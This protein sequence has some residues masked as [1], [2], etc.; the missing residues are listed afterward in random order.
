MRQEALCE[1]WKQGC[2]DG[3]R[4]LVFDRYSATSASRIPWPRSLTGSTGLHGLCG[5]F[6]SS[7]ATRLANSAAP[8][9]P[10]ETELMA[11]RCWANVGQRSC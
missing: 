3:W 4:K 11:N 8:T 7:A 1:I 5:M 2:S 10:P 6:L 9:L